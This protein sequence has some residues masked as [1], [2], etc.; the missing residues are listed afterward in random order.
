MKGAIVPTRPLNI[1]WSEPG[2][3]KAVKA[4]IATDEEMTDGEPD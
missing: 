2:A 3:V 1:A 4:I